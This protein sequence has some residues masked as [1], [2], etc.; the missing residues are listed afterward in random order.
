M[1]P[2]IRRRRSSQLLLIIPAVL[3][4]GIAAILIWAFAIEPGLLTVTRRT[5]TLE[6]LPQQ[7]Q[8]RTIVFFADVHAGK[9]YDLQR[10]DRLCRQIADEQPDLVLFGGD[11]VDFRTPQ[12]PAWIEAV[13]TSLAAIDAPFGK[14]AIA[15]NHDNRLRAEYRLMEAMLRAGGFTVL[16]NQSVWLDGIALGGLQESYFVNPDPDPVR[17]FSPE[18]LVLRAGQEKPTIP[19]NPFRIL[20]MHQPDYLA[21]DPKYA[22]L[23]LSGHSHNG[24]ITF[25]GW[26]PLRVH[27]GRRYPYGEY[28][29]ANGSRLVVTRGL[30]TVAVAARLGAPPEIVVL[31]L[32]QTTSGQP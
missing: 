5:L 20:L 2:R 30:G 12:D 25:F 1:R 13:G 6:N 23:V 19:E 16:K 9:T 11:L 29:W 27:Q 8:D 31:K 32:R 28:T 24:Q 18:G 3:V 17:A 26:A 15:G 14:Y 21:D 4:A 22:D 10:I 7:W